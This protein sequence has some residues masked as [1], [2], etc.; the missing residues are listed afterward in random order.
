MALKNYAVPGHDHFIT[1]TNNFLPEW[2]DVQVVGVTSPQVYAAIQQHASF[3]YIQQLIA[4]K[5]PNVVGP[6]PSNLFLFFSVNHPGATGEHRHHGGM[7]GSSHEHDN[8]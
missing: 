4:Q 2:W 8:D 1:D 6:I 7:G 3:D 5:N